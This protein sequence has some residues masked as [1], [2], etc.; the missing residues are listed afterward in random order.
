LKLIL[1]NAP[2]V[3]YPLGRS[4]FLGGLLLAGWLI[5]AGVTLWWWHASAPADWRP[6]LGCAAVLVAAWVMTTGWWRS[7]VGRLQWD[8][9]RW[10]WE[11]LVY[12]SGTALEPPAVVLDVQFALLL[13]LDNQAGAVWW[14]WAERSASPARWLDLR[15]AVY[16]RHRPATLQDSEAADLASGERAA[17]VE[18][19][20]STPARH[21]R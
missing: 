11:S 1:H 19:P 2:S 9:Q 10:R 8:G 16:A 4:R 14:L 12:R 17:T 13:R 5:A 7:P 15:R 20:H 3:L 21:L 6:M 18:H